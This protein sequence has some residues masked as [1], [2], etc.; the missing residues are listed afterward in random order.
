M[1]NVRRK[2]VKESAASAMGLVRSALRWGRFLAVLG[3]ILIQRCVAAFHSDRE[4]EERLSASISL[5]RHK[6]RSDLSEQV[7]ERRTEVEH[8][9]RSWSPSSFCSAG[10]CGGAKDKLSEHTPHRKRLERSGELHFPEVFVADGLWQRA[11]YDFFVRARLNR[12]ST[13]DYADGASSTRGTRFTEQSGPMNR[14]RASRRRLARIRSA[15]G[16]A[17]RRRK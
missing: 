1:S 7:D 9:L 4:R 10:D 14:H 17:A 13:D 6:A 11:R 12:L 3:S 2:T 16:A 8:S 5:S 15:S